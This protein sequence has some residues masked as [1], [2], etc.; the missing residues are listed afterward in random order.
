MF[1]DDPNL[2]R[3]MAHGGEWG[4]AFMEYLLHG[5]LDEEIKLYGRH[6][7]RVIQKGN[8]IYIKVKVLGKRWSRKIEI[9]EQ[10][11]ISVF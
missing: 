2:L 11:G 9:Y 4:T 1:K 6:G 5:T 7:G 8:N 3:I 10:L